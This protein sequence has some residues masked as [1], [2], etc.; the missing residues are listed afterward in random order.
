MSRQVLITGGN[1]GIGLELVR[2][3]SANGDKVSVLCRTTSPAL[4]KLNVNIIENV[5]VSLENNII[6]ARDKLRSDK[7]D[8]LIN[9]AGILQLE[10]LDDLN[11]ESINRQWQVNA[12]APLMLVKHLQTLLSQESKIALVSSQMG[13]IDDNGS[14]GYYGYRMSKAA[15]NAAGKSLSIDLKS[16]GISVAVL[17]PG[18]VRTQ[19]TGGQGNIEP[20][21]SARGLMHCIENLTL[22]NTGTFWNYRGEIIPW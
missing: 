16:K 10:S 9:N 22:D 14:G 11:I 4:E 21:E 13:S 5:D 8:I 18:F 19:M 15:L 7:I 17:H 3:F 12:L 20:V 1:R 2:A 6:E